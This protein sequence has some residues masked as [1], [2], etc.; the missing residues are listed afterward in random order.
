M[1][2]S[3]GSIPCP[4]YIADQEQHRKAITNWMMRVSP[5]V[6][7]DNSTFVTGN[8]LSAA[9]VGAVTM[10]PASRFGV[11]GDTRRWSTNLTIT[12]GTGVLVAPSAAFT[13]GDT[14]KS[15]T[16]N[17]NDALGAFTSDILSVNSLTSV[18]LSTNCTR[19]LAGAPGIVTVGT[20]DRSAMQAGI[21]YC[22][23]SGSGA[24]LHVKAGWYTLGGMLSIGATMSIV[25]DGWAGLRST[26]TTTTLDWATSPAKGTVLY[27]NFMD[28]SASACIRVQAHS[29]QIKNIEIEN[30]QPLPGTNWAYLSAPWCVKMYRLP[31]YGDGGDGVLIENIMMR[32][33][34]KGIRLQACS[35]AT[36]NGI[37]GQ[38]FVFGIFVSG[39]YDALRIQNVHFWPFYDVGQYVMSAQAVVADAMT[40]GRADNPMLMNCFCYHMRSLIRCFNSNEVDIPVNGFTERLQG[41][42]LGADDCQWG[43]FIQD[44][45]T[46]DLTNFY[47]YCSTHPGSRN[48][49]ATSSV[50]QDTPLRLNLTNIDFQ[51]A[52]LEAMKME[53]PSLININNLRLRN[54]NLSNVGAVAINLTLSTVCNLVNLI[55]DNGHF[56]TSLCTF[57]STNCSFNWARG[58]DISATYRSTGT[59]QPASGVGIEL[60]YDPALSAGFLVAANRTTGF[61]ADVNVH[62]KKLTIK[63]GTAGTA[64][65]TF[66]ESGDLT[67]AGGMVVANGLNV[68][69]GA[70]I[71]GN[72]FVGGTL[73]VSGT[74]VTTGVGN[75]GGAVNAKA[76]MSVSG[77]FACTGAG[78]FGT[79]LTVSAVMA[80]LGLNTGIINATVLNGQSLSVG[81]SAYINGTLSV[82]GAVYVG[83]G[84]TTTGLSVNGGLIASGNGTFG[85]T[86]TAVGQAVFGDA[87][88]SSSMPGSYANDAA[89]A[90]AGVAVGRFYRNGSALMIR[91]T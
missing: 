58:P 46:L 54:C 77:A 57:T 68:S 44:N 28:G 86:F 35:R 64:I 9:I 10:I 51:G 90:A 50:G 2:I 1:S 19:T 72:A 7:S 13:A 45:A 80:A 22:Q 59:N 87:I 3:A 74:F 5:F 32:N 83:N 41:T 42:N 14:G 15:L 85:G 55:D 38:P 49:Y 76:G 31:F 53:V 43:L 24:T 82:A 56:G 29:C 48:I 69:A 84:I 11:K 25:G 20:D 65:S 67:V 18:N 88:F 34:T 63:T 27:P 30:V 16:F 26:Q 75:F 47:S 36:L 23:G 4:P 91:V 12:S 6:T 89:A 61:Y 70:S 37:Y 78:F 79:T 17:W 21:T 81:G 33:P 62:G 71:L 66:N 39:V 60:N 40:F 8:S 73:S 52:S